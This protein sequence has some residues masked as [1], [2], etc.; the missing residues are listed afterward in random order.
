PC[1][2]RSLAGAARRYQCPKPPHQTK[3]GREAASHGQQGAAGQK[4]SKI[5]PSVS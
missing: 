5:N 2:R 3:A 1:A 4:F